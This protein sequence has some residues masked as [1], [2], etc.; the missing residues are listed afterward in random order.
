MGNGMGEGLTRGEIL[1]VVNDYIGVSG[2]YLGNFGYRSHEEFYPIYCGLDDIKVFPHQTTTRYR[3]IEI[4]EQQTSDRQARILRGILERDP[5]ESFPEDQRPKKRAIEAFI[6]KLIA[7]LERQPGVQAPVLEFTS[8]VVQRCLQDVE[9]LI[10]NSGATSGIDR[11]HTMLHGYLSVACDR[12]GIEHEP[13]STLNHLLKLLLKSHP[14]LTEL[15]PRA[16]DI[17]Q[18]LRATSTILDALNPIRNKGSLAHPNRALL[19]EAEAMLVINTAR[20]LIHYLDS[21]LYPRPD[22]LMLTNPVHE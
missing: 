14:A 3:F 12:A 2:G 10:K 19:D 20:T 7:R 11:V 18:V 4:L 9:V 22:S 1:R 6:Q 15:G 5:V 8:D 17:A 13:D 16:Q 21:K